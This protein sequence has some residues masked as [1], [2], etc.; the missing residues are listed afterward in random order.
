MD[1]VVL[2]HTYGGAVGAYGTH[3]DLGSS[4][5]TLYF[6]LLICGLSSVFFFLLVF[7]VTIQYPHSLPS[8]AKIPKPLARRASGYT[9][10]GLPSSDENQYHLT[11]PN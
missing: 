1:W 10:K 9:R 11:S 5:V 7:S 3:S 6:C 2:G 8:L 4:V